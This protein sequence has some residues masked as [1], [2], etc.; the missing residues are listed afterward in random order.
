MR[1]PVLF[2]PAETES[3]LDVKLSLIQMVTRHPQSKT[4]VIPSSKHLIPIDT[5]IAT[6]MEMLAFLKGLV[7][8]CAS[9]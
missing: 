5:P 9:G 4:V 2:L 7:F 1:C 6:S 8:E 3:K